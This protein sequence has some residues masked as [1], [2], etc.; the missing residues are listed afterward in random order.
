[1]ERRYRSSDNFDDD[2]A[3]SPPASP[4]VFRGAT[5]TPLRCQHLSHY[6]EE[7]RCFSII[8]GCYGSLASLDLIAPTEKDRDAW[9]KGLVNLMKFFRFGNVVLQLHVI[10][11]SI[12]KDPSYGR[13]SRRARSPSSISRPWNSPQKGALSL[14]NAGDGGG[15]G[16]RVVS[17]SNVACRRSSP[18]AGNS[19]GA[20]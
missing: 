14:S 20:V 1:M 6:Y 11:F 7:S 5:S 19:G 17:P 13:I 10:F 3:P 18:G 9:V 4:S 8:F 2:S 16:S 12:Y 15:A